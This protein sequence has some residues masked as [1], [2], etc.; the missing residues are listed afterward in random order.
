MAQLFLRNAQ[1]DKLSETPFEAPD[2]A[3]PEQVQQLG[4]QAFEALQAQQASEVGAPAGPIAGALQ[5][6]GEVGQAAVEF[7]KQ[8]GPAGVLSTVAPLAVP[9]GAVVK[10][11]V[12]G[13]AGVAGRAVTTLSQEG[14]LPSWG[15]A[16]EELAYG[17]IP[18]SFIKAVGPGE[19]GRILEA[20]GLSSVKAFGKKV[21]L[22]EARLISGRALKEELPAIRRAMKADVDRMYATPRRI[23]DKLGLA[24]SPVQAQG[25]AADTTKAL[26][27]LQ[28]LDPSLANRIAEA[29]SA[30]IQKAQSGQ[31][32][33]YREITE[34]RLSLLDE[35]PEF[36][37][38]RN[39]AQTALG[40]LTQNLRASAA[41][42][43]E[44]TPVANMQR[45]ADKFLKDEIVSQ[46]VALDDLANDKVTPDAVAN[47]I[48]ANPNRLNF[49]LKRAKPETVGKI[50]AATLDSM[51][52]K[53]MDAGV[54]IPEEALSS[55]R[56]LDAVVR[57]RMFTDE[58]E[59]E[60][61]LKM[62][63]KHVRQRA[64][65]KK[66]TVALIQGASFA[67][68]AAIVGNQIYSGQDVDAGDIALTFAASFAGAA[69]LSRIL[70][71]NEA[72][73]LFQRGLAQGRGSQTG[74]RFIGQALERVG[75][76]LVMGTPQA[77]V[78]PAEQIQPSLL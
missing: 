28:Q 35:L 77:G 58:K 59:I 15:E 45:K 41:D 31:P 73:R 24:A 60:K 1:G 50:R 68:P 37:R 20:L 42:M 34:F 7:A 64:H 23:A 69:V 17:F 18:E 51:F 9:G 61:S 66:I 38:N 54:L 4:R 55:F 49:V 74:V 6:A 78:V 46:R 57:K 32:L 39:E 72:N 25:L 44:G 21:S 33:T 47:F 19:A 40:Q 71:N 16:L 26:M 75:Y 53:A 30:F 36:G 48:I 5:L 56:S 63:S 43:A 52:E 13:G 76:N 3:T 70:A 67:V 11:A 27:E 14:R 12:A 10:G 65:S 22:Q 2:G 8:E 62:L 29:S